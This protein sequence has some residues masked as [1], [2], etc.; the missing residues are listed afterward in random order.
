VIN[1]MTDET[2]QNGSQPAQIKEQL[3]QLN[4]KKEE[5]FRRKQE[6][7]AKIAEK[8]NQ[9]SEY[10]KSRND[11]TKQVRDLKVERD[12]LNAEITAKITEIKAA[13]PQK[14]ETPA[15]PAPV[16]PKG[17]RLNPHELQRQIKALE[18]KIETV[19][20]S[21]DAEQKTMKMIKAMKKQL[22]AFQGAVAHRGELHAKSKEIDALKKQANT[23][24][25]KVTQ[26]AKQSQEHHEQ[27]IT[28]S[29]EIEDLKKGEETAYQ[30][31]LAAKQEY[32]TLSG[33][34]RE[35]Q[36][37][38]K[39]ARQAERK[40]QEK[41]KK[42]KEAEDQKTL[43]ERAKEAEDKMLRGEKLNTE[44]LLALQSLKE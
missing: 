1:D 43:K 17:E 39:Q 4:E 26:M 23:L 10:K 14:P 35:A 15:A 9:V 11:L 27:L 36:N 13:Q 7:S 42:Q 21:F 40:E 19:P 24:H 25:A 2:Q 31:F 16:G 44:D 41:A 37:E 38:Q 12:K 33:D 5:A 22:D 18:Q 29:K 20:M 8:I 30:E 32:M 6:I 34:V 3:E 28:L